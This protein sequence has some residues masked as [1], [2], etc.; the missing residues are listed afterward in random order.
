MTSTCPNVQRNF[1]NSEQCERK[2]SCAPPSYSSTTFELSQA[3]L[4]AYYEH[5]AIHLHYVR[6]LQSNFDTPS[7]CKVINA[8]NVPCCLC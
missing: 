8:P 6:N 7:P 2:Q 4:R 3:N 5:N 1:V